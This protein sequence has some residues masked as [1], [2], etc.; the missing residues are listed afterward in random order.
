MSVEPWPEGTSGLLVLPSGRRIRGRRLSESPPE[1]P[2]P[3]FGV[4]LSGRRPATPAWEHRWI[5]WRDFWLPG[6]PTD[7]LAVLREAYDRSNTD[8]IEIGCSGGVGRTG[9]ALAALAVLEGRS[10][11]D[12][13]EWVRRHY[14][15]R[16]VEVPWQRTFLRFIE[17]RRGTSGK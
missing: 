14:H 8:R 12:A 6:D 13:V 15:P 10:S 7:A 11:G 17:Q 2:A 3:T 5:R 16:A 4:Q 9:T 1:G